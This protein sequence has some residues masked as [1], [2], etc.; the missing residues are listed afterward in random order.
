[1]QVQIFSFAAA[2]LV[3]WAAQ[4]AA[5]DKRAATTENCETHTVSLLQHTVERHNGTR[6]GDGGSDLAVGLVL[7]NVGEPLLDGSLPN[8]GDHGHKEKGS[9]HNEGKGHGHEKEHAHGHGY[10]ALLFLFGGLT[11]GSLLLAFLERKL[12]SVPYTCALFVVGMIIS[13]IHWVKPH[14]SVFHWPTW[15]LSVDQWQ[16]IHPHMLF[17]TFLPALLFGEAMRMNVKTVYSNF[18]QIFLLACPGVILGAG[19]TAAVGKYVLPYGWDWSFAGV[20]GTILSAT[21]PVAVVALFGALGV[22]PRLTTLV[23]GESLMND[24]TAIVIFSLMLK[25]TLGTSFGAGSVLA[26]FAHMTLTSVILGSIF[27]CLACL[28]IGLCAEENYASDTMIQV[29]VTLCCAYLA[30]FLAESEFATSGVLTTTA[31]GLVVAYTAWPCF[32]SR[33][34]MKTVWETVEFIGNTLIFLLAGAMFADCVLSNKQ[35]LT[36]LDFGWLLVTYVLV[37][38]IRAAIFAILWIPL[39]MVGHEI[40][41]KEGIIMV[42][43]GLRG[44]VGLA[45]AIMVDLEPGISEERGGRLLFHV[46]GV[47]ALTILINGTTASSLLT[48]LELTKSSDVKERMLSRFSRQEAKSAADLFEAELRGDHG[49]HRFQG[50]SRSIVQKM[51]PALQSSAEAKSVVSEVVRSEE[52]EL[53]L[54][55]TYREVFLKIIQSRYW[56]SIEEGIVPR[57]LPVARILLSSTDAALEAS[58]RS[59][60]D[61]DSIGDELSLQGPRLTETVMAS[62]VECRPFSWFHR[63]RR[64]WSAD[65]QQVRKVYAAVCFMDAHAHAQHE[66]LE[67]YGGEDT[68]EKEVQKKVISESQQ[69]SAQAKQ[70]LDSVS[71]QYV[72]LAK[73]EMLARRILHSQ[74]HRV[75]HV[76]ETGI[77]TASEAGNLEREADEAVRRIVNLPKDVWLTPS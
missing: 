68:L 54:L 50:A 34:T 42:W 61:W 30:F 8:E 41:F 43:S 64:I 19:L 25:I 70:L 66:L 45:L 67:H 7:K 16:H 31:S 35:H 55:S 15:F 24:G 77:L 11:I 44:A 57:Y 18:A 3:I 40:S 12:P 76:L 39:N 21:D 5:V 28:V 51:V 53:Q 58:T 6:L 69:Q 49:D 65:S 37:M 36:V 23:A 56:E 9:G 17:Y 2:V 60:C 73:S 63:L 71:P 20:F 33:E 32:V 75:H 48:Y 47:A 22:S 38:L 46:G 62:L 72:E 4:V 27:G 10:V 59:L 74:I 14:S 26:F 52:V 29:V 13:F 1:M